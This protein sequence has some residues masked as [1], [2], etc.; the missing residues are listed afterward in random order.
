MDGIWEECM[1]HSYMRQLLLCSVMVNMG[2]NYSDLKQD[3]EYEQLDRDQ[4]FL[5]AKKTKNNSLELH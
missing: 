3:W 4:K 1:F 5:V 2:N